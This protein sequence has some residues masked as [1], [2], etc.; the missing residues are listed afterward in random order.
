MTPPKRTLTSSTC[1]SGKAFYLHRAFWQSG[2]CELAT[3]AVDAI[4]YQAD[5]PVGE[6]TDDGRRHAGTE[7]LRLSQLRKVRA[8]L[9]QHRE[10]DASDQRAGHGVDA[11]D[12]H[13]QR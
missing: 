4:R 1:R 3:C 8:D 7:V 9:R 2:G 12:V 11:A 5:D 13:R 10:E 6:T